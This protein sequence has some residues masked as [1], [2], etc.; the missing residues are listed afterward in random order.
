[1]CAGVAATHHGALLGH[2]LVQHPFV[3]QLWKL[4]R[5]LGSDAPLHR[6]LDLVQSGDV[7]AGGELAEH[8]E[9]SLP[10]SLSFAT[11]RRGVYL[12]ACECTSDVR[13]EVRRKK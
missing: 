7:L 1:M 12:S 11:E 9:R 4:L 8:V 6:G 10:L 2:E 3:L 5:D 13:P